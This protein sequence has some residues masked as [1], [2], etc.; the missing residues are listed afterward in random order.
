M[1]YAVLII[2]MKNFYNFHSQ[3]YQNTVEDTYRYNVNKTLSLIWV[4]C[5]IF[6]IT[7]ISIERGSHFNILLNQADV[8]LNVSETNFCA[9]TC[10]RFCIYA[11]IIL[12]TK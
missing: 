7:Q 11:L 9:E 2:N 3:Q 10:G 8:T 12:L 5:A 1:N 4:V 6:M